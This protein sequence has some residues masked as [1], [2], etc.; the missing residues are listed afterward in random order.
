VWVTNLPASGFATPITYIGRKGK[1]QFVVI[2]AGGGNKYDS[3]FDS[4]L[5]AFSFP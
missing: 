3:K 2:A 1:K 4:K 5:I